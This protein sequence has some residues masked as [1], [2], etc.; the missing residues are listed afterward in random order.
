MSQNIRKLKMK[1]M[2]LKTIMKYTML[3]KL[4][5]RGWQYHDKH[6]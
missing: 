4:C 3:E 6:A 1:H 5:D 2:R